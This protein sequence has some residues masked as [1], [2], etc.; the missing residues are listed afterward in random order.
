MSCP[1]KF[2]LGIPKQGFHS[3]RFLGLALNDFLGTIGLALITSYTL[4]IKLW[5]S[6]LGWFILGELLHYYF[7]VQT[8][9]LTLLG[10]NACS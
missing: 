10:I 7:G 1:Y 5:I 4:K 3:Q 8:E 6:F 2:I 9:F